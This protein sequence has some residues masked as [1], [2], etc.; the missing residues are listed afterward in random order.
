MA[1]MIATGGAKTLCDNMPGTATGPADLNQYPLCRC[2]VVKARK[3]GVPTEFVPIVPAPPTPKLLKSP[4]KEK[5]FLP[6]PYKNI[7]CAIQ[8]LGGINPRKLRRAG[9]WTEF[10]EFL[11]AS[12]R[13]RIFRHASTNSVDSI[14]TEL[15]GY[16]YPVEDADSLLEYLKDQ[17]KVNWSQEPQEVQM[18]NEDCLELRINELLI[19][20][21]TLR[22]QIENL[23]RAEGCFDPVEMEEPF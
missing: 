11:P 17:K 3:L 16:G 13:R 5:P 23:T 4:G 6:N 20:N 1:H 18:T 2:C 14:A 22:Q 21:E 19:E 7:L 9:W 8:Y 15:G 12:I 10:Y